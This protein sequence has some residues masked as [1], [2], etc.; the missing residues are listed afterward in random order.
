M[1]CE[2]V[3]DAIIANGHKCELLYRDHRDVIKM[4]RATVVGEEVKR[5]DNGKEDALERDEVEGK[6]TRG[7]QSSILWKTYF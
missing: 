3:K 5:R 4:L 7:H 2:A 1:Y 6:D